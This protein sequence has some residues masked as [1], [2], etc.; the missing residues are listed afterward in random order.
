V[1]THP[2]V[3]R[4]RETRPTLAGVATPIQASGQ[5]RKYR[6]GQYF[7]KLSMHNGLVH[8]ICEREEMASIFGHLLGV[9]IV[10]AWACSTSGIVFPPGIP[11]GFILHKCAVMDFLDGCAMAAD[12]VAAEIWVRNH[13]RVVADIFAYM[14]WIGDD[15]RGLEDIMMVENKLLLVDNGLTGPPVFES[16][17]RSS[18]PSRASLAKNT[19]QMLKKC[20][21]GKPSFVAFV[22][23]DLRVSCDELRFPDFIDRCLAMDSNDIQGIIEG[24]GMKPSIAN[25]LDSRRRTLPDEYAEWLEMLRRETW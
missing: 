16:P 13:I 22:I 20:Y 25:V 5:N 23:R 8:D 3:M 21:P 17:L 19:K 10:R 11:N 2:A 4:H 14:H 9:P 12:R 7:L 18:H 15:D 1:N 24:L 6:L